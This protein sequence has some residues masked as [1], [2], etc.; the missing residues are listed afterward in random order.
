MKEMSRLDW[1]GYRGGCG[2]DVSRTMVV[3][4][5]RSPRGVHM[6]QLFSQYG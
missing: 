3:E 5:V 6:K 1:R 2:G 4:L